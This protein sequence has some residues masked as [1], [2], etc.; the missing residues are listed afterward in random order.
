MK[1]SQC[2]WCHRPIVWAKSEDG[3]R[4]IPVDLS[5][6]IYEVE[7]VADEVVAHRARGTIGVNHHQTCTKLPK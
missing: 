1:T 6:V 5:S 4:S 7:E 3:V 2:K